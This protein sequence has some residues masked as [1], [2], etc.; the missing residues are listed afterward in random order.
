LPS[1]QPFDDLLTSCIRAADLRIGGR[2]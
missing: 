1:L 2:S